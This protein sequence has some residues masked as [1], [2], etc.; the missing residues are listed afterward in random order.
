MLAPLRLCRWRPRQ[1]GHRH[2]ILRRPHPTGADA[3]NRQI[4]TE[5]ERTLEQFERLDGCVVDSFCDCA[6]GFEYTMAIVEIQAA[7]YLVGSIASSATKKLMYDPG[8][9]DV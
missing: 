1:A 7:E 8:Q 3:R 2:R 9:I 4:N 6:I 5:L